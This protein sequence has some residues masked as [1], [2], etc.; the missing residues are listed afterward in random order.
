MAAAPAAPDAAPSLRDACPRI[1]AGPR[2]L[3]LP[4]P[5]AVGRTAYRPQLT[6]PVWTRCAGPVETV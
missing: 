6:R 1:P 3:P 2:G 5:S 4:F